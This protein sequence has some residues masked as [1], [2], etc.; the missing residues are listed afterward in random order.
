MIYSYG[1]YDASGGLEITV[2]DYDLYQIVQVF[3]ENH[4]TLAVVYPGDTVKIT[5]K[6]LT[7]GDHVY[8]FMRTQ[9]RS[10]DEKGLKELNERQ[11]AVVIMNGTSNPYV[12]EVKYEPDSF[13][14][15][16][17]Y[18]I[19]PYGIKT[20]VI[21]EGFIENLEDIVFPHYQIVNLGGW[22]GLPAKHAL[23]FVVLPR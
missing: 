18:L 16:R 20:A 1:V 8:L 22:A 2:P 6:D 9:R 13:N 19:G 5:K 17:A 10:M 11:D 3:D 15:L 21:H 14:K 4:V 23:Y 12:S 7:Y